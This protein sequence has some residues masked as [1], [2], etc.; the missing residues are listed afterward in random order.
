MSSNLVTERNCSSMASD[1]LVLCWLQK[2]YVNLTPPLC[3]AGTTRQKFFFPK[4]SRSL[5]S[6]MQEDNT[7]DSSRS[8]TKRTR[9]HV[10]IEP[11]SGF[12]N[13]SAAL[14]TR[15]KLTP[16][17]SSR[18]RPESPSK[19]LPFWLRELIPGIFC[20][21]LDEVAWT[22]AMTELAE[23]LSQKLEGGVIPL[24]LKVYLF[25]G[26]DPILIDLF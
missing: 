9:T 6:I 14:S 24:A 2:T 19:D 11:H 15:T 23:Q 21:K 12:S 4:R 22:G 8:P 3:I 20:E 26:M 13:S 1:E 5:D 10:Q 16:K 18:T 25:H 17:T 7:S